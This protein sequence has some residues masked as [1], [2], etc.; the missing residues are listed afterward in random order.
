VSGEPWTFTHAPTYERGSWILRHHGHDVGMVSLLPEV[1]Y[2]AV[3]LEAIVA[4]LNATDAALTNASR[5]PAR[6]LPE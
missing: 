4:T 2:Q 6:P 1:G 3:R 5:R